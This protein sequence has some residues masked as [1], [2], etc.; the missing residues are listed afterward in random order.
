M[1]NLSISLFFIVSVIILV[2]QQSDVRTESLA[3]PTGYTGAPGE[4]TCGNSSCHNSTPTT[5]TSSFNK[6]QFTDFTQAPLPGYSGNEGTTLNVSLKFN[7]NTGQNYSVYGFSMT[8]LYADGTPAGTLLEGNGTNADKT[9]LSTV[10][11][12]DYIG[13]QNAN[14]NSTWVFK[15][16]L[17]QTIN[18]DIIFYISGN[19]ANGNG[20]ADAADDIFLAQYRMGKNSTNLVDDPS[21]SITINAADVSEINIFPN[22]VQSELNLQF[23]LNK[24]GRTR[25]EIVDL[26]GATVSR[27]F[28]TNMSPGSYTQ[29]FSINESLNSGIYLVRIQIEEAT[30]YQKIM[31]Q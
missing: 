30:Y 26:R 5:V 29:K 17:D 10:G 18:K 22:P 12:K 11:G 9:S 23:N 2:L 21:S 27:L 31:V 16:Q 3:P 15:Y 1:K 25:A 14:S 20:I 4:S 28:E 13:H 8:A 24:G 7:Q 19:G 6:L